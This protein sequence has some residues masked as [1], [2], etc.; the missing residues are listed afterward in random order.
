MIAKQIMGMLYM[1]GVWLLGRGARLVVGR[2][3]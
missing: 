1:F 3:V 2:L